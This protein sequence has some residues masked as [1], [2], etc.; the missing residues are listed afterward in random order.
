[1]EP[2]ELLVAIP[3]LSRSVVSLNN[4]PHESFRREKIQ[5]DLLAAEALGI[6][7]WKAW[8]FHRSELDSVSVIGHGESMRNQ[9]LLSSQR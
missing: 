7:Q 2:D 3:A 6:S 4:E 5:D 9:A 8:L 1:M